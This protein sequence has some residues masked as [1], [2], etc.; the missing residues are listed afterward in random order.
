MTRAAETSISL[1]SAC[2]TFPLLSAQSRS[3]RN[4]I[5]QTATAGQLGVNSDGH[6]FVRG[7]NDVSLEI[8]RGERVGLLGRNGS[9]KSTLLRVLSGIYE[10]TSGKAT[11]I[12]KPTTLMDISLGINPEATGLQNV[13]LQAALMGVPRKKMRE[14]VGDIVDF[15]ELGDFI[16]LPVRTYSSGMQLRLALAISTVYSPEILIMDEWLSVGDEAFRVKAEKKIR[17]LVDG[18]GI[19]IIATHSR[20][21]VESICTRAILLDQGRIVHDGPAGEVAAA[22]FSS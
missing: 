17:E 3:L 21:L 19:L 15:S 6:H 2:V 10:P 16:H 20:E 1:L 12:G 13:F 22:Y 11:V 14:R 8:T 4:R 7:L 9:G 5:V 18:A